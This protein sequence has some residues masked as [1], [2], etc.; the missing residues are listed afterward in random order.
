MQQEVVNPSARPERRA[1][2]KRTYILLGVVAVLLLLGGVFAR[3][4]YRQVKAWRARQ[5]AET[6]KELLEKKEYQQAFQKANAALQMKPDDIEVIRLTAD[7]ATRVRAP[8][9]PNLWNNLI[10]HPQATQQ[11]RENYAEFLMM[12][13]RVEAAESMV[14]QLLTKEPV[15]AKTYF[16]AA[17]IAQSRRDTP[18]AIQ[19]LRSALEKDTTHRPS[20]LML[21]S[22]LLSSQSPTDQTEAKKRLAN[23]ISKTNDTLRVSAMYRLAR[24]DLPKPEVERLLQ[25]VR[26]NSNP[27]LDEYFLGL[28][29]MKKLDPSS[30]QKL[31]AQ[32]VAK[33]RTG[34]AE[35]RVALGTW[36][37]SQGKF[38]ETAQSLP[39]EQGLKNPQLSLIYI[40]SLAGLERWDDVYKTLAREDLG[41]E[42]VFHE[43][44]RGSS[45][46]KIKKEDLAKIHWSKAMTLASEQPEKLRIVAELAE[47][48]DSREEAITAYSKMM[49]VPNLANNANRAMLRLLHQSGDT[50]G[51]RELI[52]KMSSKTRFDTSLQN[53]HAYLNILLGENVAQSKAVAE[54]LHAQKP[55][56]LGFKTTLALA[57]LR[58]KNP[59]AAY[60]VFGATNTYNVAQFP[61]GCKAVYAATLALNNREKDAQQIVKTLQTTDLKPEEKE[62]VKR[63]LPANEARN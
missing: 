36:L 19:F 5:F 43:A 37:N 52:K 42:P 46:R 12:A 2:K 33:F 30:A 23:V 60:A 17:Q 35:E 50:R 61:P 48:S 20:E 53:Y 4:A 13:N 34:K 58:E 47:R 62:L 55:E 29:L 27:S 59:A 40:E 22:L 38:A 16:M 26:E 25:M 57:Y 24:T 51:M 56:D 49:E 1:N 63:W 3:P 54:Q 9:A 10:Y 11:D 32:A 45:A 39:P 28:D 6:A 7:V 31:I 44:M 21:G 8:I 15:S 41:L 18:R 14:G